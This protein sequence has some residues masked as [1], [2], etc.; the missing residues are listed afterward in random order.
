MGSQRVR[1]DWVTFTFTLNCKIKSAHPKGNQPWIFTGRA[2]AEAW[3]SN[4]LATCC[5]E[6]T[7]WKRPWCW[8]RLRARGQGGG[9]GWGAWMASLTQRTYV[10]AN[11]EREWRTGKP[12]VLQS[13]GSPRIEHDLMTQQQM[14]VELDID[15][16]N[17][18]FLYR[19]LF[20]LVHWGYHFIIFLVL[21]CWEEI[22]C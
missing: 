22:F 9:R 17:T 7:H 2:D 21:L 12:G 15:N 6:P 18:T 16:C 5:E 19:E 1:H 4:T 13:M 3:S 20:L 10:C 14:I 11:S 8:E